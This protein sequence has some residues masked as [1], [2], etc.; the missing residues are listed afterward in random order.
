V[1]QIEQSSTRWATVLI[2]LH[3]VYRS[4]SRELARRLTRGNVDRQGQHAQDSPRGDV[5][6]C[7]LARQGGTTNTARGRV[8]HPLRKYY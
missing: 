3:A 6:T 4:E 1:A 5:T 7:Y 8:A 2:E